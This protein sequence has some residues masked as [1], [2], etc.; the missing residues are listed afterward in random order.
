MRGMIALR[1]ERGRQ[2]Q[3][4]RR[5]ELNAERATLTPLDRYG[6][7]AFGHFALQE[8]KGATG[9]PLGRGVFG[10]YAE[11]EAGSTTARIDP[12]ERGILGS[13]PKP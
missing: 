2:G 4:L 9:W 12:R 6:N 3:N 7:M 11:G 5:T 8:D 10:G 13:A 1:I